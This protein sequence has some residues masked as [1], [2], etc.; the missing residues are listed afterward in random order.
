MMHPAP[1][2][3]DGAPI[4]PG[5]RSVTSNLRRLER[6]LRIEAGFR[7]GKET[8]T[9]E[10]IAKLHELKRYT[11]HLRLRV[12]R[13]ANKAIL[14]GPQRKA[15][16]KA[17]RAAKREAIKAVWYKFRDNGASC[18]TCEHFRQSAP[19]FYCTLSEDVAGMER[20]EPTGL[21]SKYKEGDAL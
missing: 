12:F 20:V 19:Y 17:K 11:K 1:K 7:P 2:G 9:H 15:T 21:C 16:L 6:Y 14:M 10:Q 13:A 8:R 5:Y 4:V 18:R 3:K